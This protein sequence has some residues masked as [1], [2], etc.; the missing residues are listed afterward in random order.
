M[1]IKRDYLK[2]I[3]IISSQVPQTL[4]ARMSSHHRNVWFICIYSNSI[5]QRPII[6]HIF[7]FASALQDS[8]R[9]AHRPRIISYISCCV[10]GRVHCLTLTYT[11]LNF[12]PRGKR[13]MG[14][15]LIKFCFILEAHHR[16]HPHT[17][18]HTES[19]RAVKMCHFALCAEVHTRLTL[20]M[21]F[22]YI[23]LVADLS[24]KCVT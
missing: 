2:R 20:H 17:H 13:A 12:H 21:F 9:I 1:Y 19:A 18:T 10:C 4:Y 6:N 24:G 3:N 5:N 7:S 16:R 22:C 14:V 11:I 23:W 15:V 8:A